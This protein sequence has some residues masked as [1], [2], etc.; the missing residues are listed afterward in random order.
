LQS[1]FQVPSTAHALRRTN[2]AQHLLNLTTAL[3]QPQRQL[4]TLGEISHLPIYRKAWSN[5]CQ[6]D[7][8][9]I[10]VVGVDAR[11]KL[12]PPF[13]D[14]LVSRLPLNS[15]L[16]CVMSASASPPDTSGH[17]DNVAVL[18][19]TSP[20]EKHRSTKTFSLS[21]YGG[22]PPDLLSF[23]DFVRG[24]LSS[25]SVMEAT[26]SEENRDRTPYGK[27]LIGW[28]EKGRGVQKGRK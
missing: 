16:P 18:T 4:Q 2:R 15:G 26:L 24:E 1:S 22:L 23:S 7:D 13:V 10:R 19:Q 3:L 20:S 5:R 9:P 27:V 6:L 28:C 14:E 12:H 21:E 11:Q 17:P 8:V 25:E